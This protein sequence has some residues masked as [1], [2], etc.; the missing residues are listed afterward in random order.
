MTQ[1]LIDVEKERLEKAAKRGN[2]PIRLLEF[3]L[4][5]LKLWFRPAAPKLQR[6]LK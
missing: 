5:R 3:R 2:R 1:M 6:N 4:P